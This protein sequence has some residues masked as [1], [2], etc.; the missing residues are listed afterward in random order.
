MGTLDYFLARG[1]RLEQDTR[2]N[3]RATGHLDDSIRAAIRA[4]KPVL[5]VELQWREFESLLAIVGPAYNTPEHEYAEMREAARGDLANALI[6]YRSLAKQID[7]KNH[8]E[9]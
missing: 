3:V 7:R 6:A 4:Q 5:V 2:E 1:V 8:G 9:S